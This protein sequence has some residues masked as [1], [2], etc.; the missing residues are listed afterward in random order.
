MV[1]FLGPCK[2]V[3]ASRSF[4]LVCPLKTVTAPAVTIQTACQVWG[5]AVLYLFMMHALWLD[6]A[7]T[8]HKLF[9]LLSGTAGSA[10]LQEDLGLEVKL[11]SRRRR[12]CS[13]H[14]VANRHHVFPKWFCKAHW[15]SW[16]GVLKFYRDHLSC[17]LE[18][19]VLTVRLPTALH[20]AGHVTVSCAIN[21]VSLAL[22]FL[23]SQSLVL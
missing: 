6:V 23:Q 21:T 2:T 15:P 13:A 11:A 7:F 20:R 17:S 9:L 18:S 19:C 14:L 5:F 8:F 22:I 12:F 16:V 3:K 4:C 1:Y 10:S